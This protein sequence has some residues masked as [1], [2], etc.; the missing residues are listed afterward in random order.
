LL[1]IKKG[2]FE[3]LCESQP[4]LG[5]KLMRNIVRVFSQRIRDNNDE[6]RDMLLWS[7]GKKKS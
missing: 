7:L 2:D 5:M 3:N 6:F 4:A 1:C